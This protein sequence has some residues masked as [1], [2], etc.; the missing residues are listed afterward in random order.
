MQL[1]QII[2]HVGIEP[3]YREDA[4][5]I[6]NADC[7]DILPKMP[8]KCV[9]LVVTDPPYGIG[10]ASGGQS[11]INARIYENSFDDNPEYIKAIVIPAMKI[12]RQLSP[13]VIVT[14]GIRCLML[15]PQPND[16]GDMYAPAASRRGSW[17]FSN[18]NPILYYGRDPRA[19]IGSLPT[20]KQVTI[21]SEKN[22]HPCPKPLEFVCWLIHKGSIIKDCMVLDPFLGSG[23]TAVAAKQL[24]RKYI[25][26]EIEEK[27]CKIAVQRLAQEILKV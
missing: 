4:G 15:Y 14:P 21:K 11:R 12:C 3:Y 24:G 26:I 25:G 10:G 6:Y 27:Y 22:D 8:E 18:C 2:E 23:T 20:S 1:N 5:V 13:I 16:L 9:D 17:G 7:L 19:G